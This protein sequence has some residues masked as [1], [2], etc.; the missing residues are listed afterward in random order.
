MD[1]SKISQQQSEARKVDGTL[2][3]IPE[4]QLT[5]E[6]RWTDAY[7]K[8]VVVNEYA[9]ASQWRKQNHDHR[10]DESE[11][12]YLA[13]YPQ[14]VWP[15][16][17]VPRS[18]LG[19]PITFEQ[20]EAMKP[21]MVSAL[22]SE[23]QWFEMEG[24]YGTTPKTA[25][26]IQDIIY[27]QLCYSNPREQGRRAVGSALLFGNGIIELYWDRRMTDKQKFIPQFIQKK[28][29]IVD[30]ITGQWHNMPTGEYSMKMVEEKVEELINRPAMRHISIRDFFIDPHAPSVVPNEARYVQKRIMMPIADIVALGE[31]D[32]FDVP[33]MEDLKIILNNFR[34]YEPSDQSRENANSYRGVN[35]SSTVEYTADATIGRVEVIIRWSADRLVWVVG[36]AK[37]IYNHPNPFGFIPYYNIFYAD[38]SDRFY[39]LSVADVVEGE[40]RFQ[41]SLVNKRIDELSLSMDPPT[42][43]TNNRLSTFE[44]R[45][46]PGNVAHV[47]DPMK[48]VQRQFPGNV[49]SQVYVEQQQSDIRVQRITGQNESIMQGV[50]TPQNPV[51]RSAAGANMQLQ[52]SM[53]RLIHTVENAES[54]VFEPIV[55]DC[56]TLNKMYLA[57]DEMQGIAELYQTDPVEM[58]NSTV[59]PHVRAGSKMA[60]KQVMA[61]MF[62]LVMQ[63][64][65]SGGV[66]TQ[67]MSQGLTVD[68]QEMFRILFDAAGYTRKATLIRPMNEKEQQFVQQQQEQTKQ[69]EQM[70]FEMQRERMGQLSDMQQDKGTMDYA[71]EI[72]KVLMKNESDESKDHMKGMIGLA[73]REMDVG[74][75]N[76]AK[77]MDVD[78]KNYAARFKAKSDSEKS[79]NS[80]GGKK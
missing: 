8:R 51:A 56:W 68:W 25:H 66:L 45:Y 44:L 61:Q 13:E 46:R 24:K 23:D 19:V 35:T 79:K 65:S 47:E 39:G 11:R 59:I 64:L 54:L 34:E 77:E 63:S 29:R 28:K 38:L 49:T 48:D 60:S 7:A 26:D 69:I 62:P 6:S 37:T 22:F 78:Q 73:D 58:F 57:P 5:G 18:S 10:W 4:K 70:K 14:L 2:Q 43:T 33:S 67:L 9:E 20:I 21:R 31:A 55:A 80:G 1:T 3:D 27:D 30:P 41:Q 75:K 42:V 16:S 74:Q 17:R 36:K 40:Q 76:R 71:K 53:S 32:G 52:A 15:G 72:A 50:P 12:L